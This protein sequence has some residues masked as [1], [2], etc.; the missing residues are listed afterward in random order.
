MIPQKTTQVIRLPRA[1][2]E[3]VAIWASAINMTPAQFVEFAIKRW[4]QMAP[5]EALGIK[6]LY[7]EKDI[8]R[9]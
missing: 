8:S 4:E 9:T 6:G 1:L 5:S 7:D 2:A 3:R